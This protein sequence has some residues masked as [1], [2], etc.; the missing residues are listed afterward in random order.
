MKRFLLLTAFIGCIIIP[1][2]YY[3]KAEELNVGS[4][5][6]DSCDTSITVSYSRDLVP[7][8]QDYCYSCHSGPNP[9]STYNLDTYTDLAGWASTGDLYGCVYR[10]V[11]YNPMPPSFALDSCRMKLFAKWINAGAPN[12]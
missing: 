6:F 12:N 2:C 10:Q 4:G 8:L 11:G 5:I 9:S 1:G 3:D 7:I